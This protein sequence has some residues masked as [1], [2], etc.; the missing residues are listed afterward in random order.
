MAKAR[1]LYEEAHRI[2]ETETDH[3]Q[4]PSMQRQLLYLLNSLVSLAKK[5]GD[6]REVRSLSCKA[7][8]CCRAFGDKRNAACMLESMA[9]VA[10]QQEQPEEAFSGSWAQQP[11][12]GRQLAQSGIPMTRGSLTAASP[13]RRR[14]WKKDA[15]AVA[16]AEGQTMNLEQAIAYAL[17]EAAP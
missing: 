11:L 5:Q 4:L 8:L 17:K 16:F 1:S 3:R 14:C 13:K 2:L 9:G 12:C 10:I 15:F 6:A 7:L